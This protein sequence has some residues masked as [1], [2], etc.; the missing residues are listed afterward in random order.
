MP[1]HETHYF[2]TKVENFKVPQWCLLKK[3]SSILI[4]RWN[5][6]HFLCD[7]KWPQP[8]LAPSS[9][10]SYSPSLMV[11]IHC[12][13]FFWKIKFHL[14]FFCW[15]EFFIPFHFIYLTLIWTAVGTSTFK[16]NSCFFLED[17]SQMQTAH[18]CSTSTHSWS[19]APEKHSR[20]FLHSRASADGGTLLSQTLLF[21]P[22]YVSFHVSYPSFLAAPFSR[23]LVPL[24]VAICT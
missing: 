4:R 20:I 18:P 21:S 19:P 13:H 10:L 15:G 9:F 6:V 24:L 3:T 14:F 8:R 17:P 22:F 1:T 5:W 11:Q 7:D 2:A 16:Q 12:G 23:P